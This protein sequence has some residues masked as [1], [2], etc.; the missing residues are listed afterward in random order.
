[1]AL[2]LWAHPLALPALRTELSRVLKRA[3]LVALPGYLVSAGVALIAGLA[4]ATALGSLQVFAV[5]VGDFAVGS[6]FAALDG[7]LVLALGWRLL[8]RLQQARFS[9]PAKLG[10]ALAVTVP[11]RATVALVAASATG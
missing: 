10:L 3:A 6:G 7:V 1:L 5:S 8:P 2:V 4:V 11:L 9:L